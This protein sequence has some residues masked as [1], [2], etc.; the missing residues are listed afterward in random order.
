MIRDVEITTFN[1]RDELPSAWQEVVGDRLFVRMTMA[2]FGFAEES[3]GLIVF[4][5]DPGGNN[6][7]EV[8]IGEALRPY[9]MLYRGYYEHVAEVRFW[10]VLTLTARG[11]PADK[12]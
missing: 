7:F 3:I 5:G 11:M 12:V 6:L 8:G 9:H 1:D 2:T 10:R 4:R